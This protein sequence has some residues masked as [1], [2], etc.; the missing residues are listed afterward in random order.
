[1]F[2]WPFQIDPNAAGRNLIFKE[3]HYER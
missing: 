1:V 3:A 2:V